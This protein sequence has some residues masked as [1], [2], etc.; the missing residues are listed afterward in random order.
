MNI[1]IYNLPNELLD[2][3]FYYLS[4]IKKAPLNKFY[5]NKY[6]NL[7]QKNFT[8]ERY[9]S[10]IRDIIRNDYNFIF[11]HIVCKNINNWITEN[12]F[13]YKNVIYKNYISFYINYC[14]TYSSNKCKNLIF[15]F[16]EKSSI[17]KT[18]LKNKKIKY[19]KWI[20]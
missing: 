2:I 16:L 7:L 19:Y 14:N 5:Y 1:L 8:V 17:P 3:I 11:E 15:I 18:L 12:N 4:N 13:Y 6:N 10:F 9:N 20:K